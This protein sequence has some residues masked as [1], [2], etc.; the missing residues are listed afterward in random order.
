MKSTVLSHSAVVTTILGVFT[1]YEHRGDN[2]PPADIVTVILPKHISEEKLLQVAENVKYLSDLVVEL[3]LP[4][5]N[6]TL[7]SDMITKA[8]L[9]IP[10]TD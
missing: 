7:W 8:E 6:F 1:W 2:E 3:E 9:E 5:G 4:V 10:D